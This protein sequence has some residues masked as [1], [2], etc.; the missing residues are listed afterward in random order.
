MPTRLLLD[1]TIIEMRETVEKKM[2]EFNQ[3]G[4]IMEEDN[5]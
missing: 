4:F 1:L 5:V 2:C 3:T